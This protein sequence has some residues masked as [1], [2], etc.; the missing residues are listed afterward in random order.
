MMKATMILQINILIAI[1]SST[2]TQTVSTNVVDWINLINSPGSAPCPTEMKST[3]NQC[4]VRN[5]SEAENIQPMC[6]HLIM[7]S[8]ISN[9]VSY[10][11]DIITIDIS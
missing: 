10:I 5:N 4:F 7:K 9:N 11:I 1:L 8:S 2:S 6:E 3:L